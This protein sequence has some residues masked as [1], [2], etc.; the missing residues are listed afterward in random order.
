M[1]TIKL[2]LSCYDVPQTVVAK[3]G[4][5]GRKFRAVLSDSNREYSVPNGAKLSVWYSGTSGNGNYSQIGD[6][7]AFSVEGSTVT[8]ELITQMLQNKGG[9]TLCLMLHGADGTQIAMWNIPYTVEPVPGMGSAGAEQYYTALSETATIAADSAKKA[10]AAAAAAEKTLANTIPVG[11]F[12]REIWVNSEEDTGS[13]WDQLKAAFDEMAGGTVE[14]C[15]LMIVSRYAEDQIPGGNYVAELAKTGYAD[16]G[17]YGFIRLTSYWA[18]GF[19]VPQ[20]YTN[21]CNA[22]VWRGVKSLTKTLAPTLLWTNEAPKSSIKTTIELPAA[23]DNYNT[24][25]IVV[26]LN[27]SW[28]YAT[29]V[30]IR[31]DGSSKTGVAYFPAGQNADGSQVWGESKRYFFLNGRDVTMSIGYHEGSTSNSRCIPYKIYGLNM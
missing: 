17:Y 24:I 9:G 10:Q 18:D 11:L 13:A 21:I 26:N 15:R 25:L 29:P 14:Y 7:S 12:T 3:Q 20:E 22:G 16:G 4:D 27:T 19:G 8:V 31:K 6:S 23:A 5:V 30:L 28:L 1:Q 2:D